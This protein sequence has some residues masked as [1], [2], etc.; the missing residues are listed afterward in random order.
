MRHMSRITLMA[1]LAFAA[2]AGTAHAGGWATV[3]LG[4][5][6]SGLAPGKPWHVEL[7]VK[8]HGVT[9][10]DGVTPS[11]RIDNGEG[12]VRT[13]RARPA[14]RPGTYVAKVTFPSAGTWQTRIYDGFTNAIPHRLSPLTVP[15]AG[16]SADAAAGGSTDAA[17]LRQSPPPT[18][19]AAPLRPSPPPTVATSE[20]GG[21]PWPQTIAIA[22][23]ALLWL[24]GWVAASGRPHAL[25]R[26][27]GSFTLRGR[28]A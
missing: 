15:S 20:A 2:I 18:V 13:F 5:A 17:P 28:A 3:E 9:P 26:R 25:R 14:G 21:F 10:L 8:Q 1:L 6:P 16:G 19:A 23:M 27:S 7:L 12:V 24:A 11:V 4:E 22:L